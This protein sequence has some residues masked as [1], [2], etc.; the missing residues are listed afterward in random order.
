VAGVWVLAV[1]L[2][3]LC[4]PSEAA[5]GPR[6][7]ASPEKMDFGSMRQG[8]EKRKVFLLRNTGDGALVVDQIRPSCAECVVDQKAT[9]R[10]AP[11]EQVELP[12]TYQAAAVPGKYTAHITLHTNVPA[13]PLKRVYLEVQITERGKTPFVELVPTEINLGLVL[14]N[15]PARHV[16]KVRN[17]GAAALRLDEL[18][19]GPLVSVQGPRVRELPPGAD[20]DIVLELRGAETGI[21][22]TNVTIATN[23]PERPTVTVPIYGYVASAEQIE[24]LARGVVIVPQRSAAQGA[25]LLAVRVTNNQETAVSVAGPGRE[26]R[27]LMLAPGQS[28]TLEV[29]LEN[30]G[31][32]RTVPIQVLLPTKTDAAQPPE[33]KER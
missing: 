8:E 20:S 27:P 17:T 9:Y 31:G 29:R 11:A 15:A 22:R 32:E 16:L 25:E 26:S 4:L 18:A 5:V 23:D 33:R 10:L 13:E 6:L 24:R 1:L 28:G 12:V 2:G 7:E 19:A 3:G 14:L 21:V 30:G